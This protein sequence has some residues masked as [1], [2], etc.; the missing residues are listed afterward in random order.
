[1]ARAGGTDVIMTPSKKRQQ[2]EPGSENNEPPPIRRRDAART[3]RLRAVIRYMLDR[4]TLA[5]GD[6][7]LLAAHFGLTRQRVNQLVTRERALMNLESPRSRP[8]DDGPTADR[9]RTP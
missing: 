5:P 2:P 8:S 7:A 1:M 3:A 4:G 9:R 6:Q